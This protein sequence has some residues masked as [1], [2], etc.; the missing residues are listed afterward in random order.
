[1]AQQLRLLDGEE[2][3]DVHTEHAIEH[4]LDEVVG[5]AV[6]DELRGVEPWVATSQVVPVQRA[7]ESFV[8]TSR[9]CSA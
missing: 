3:R 5:P 6:L 7:G 4:R 9:R 1:V 2:F 8:A